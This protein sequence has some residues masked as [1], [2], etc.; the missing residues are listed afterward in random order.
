MTTGRRTTL[1]LALVAALF[2]VAAVPAAGASGSDRLYLLADDVGGLYWSTVARDPELGMTTISRTCGT[3]APALPESRDRCFGYVD[4]SGSR[5]Y[6]FDFHPA[7]L[8]DAKPAAS[9]EPLRFHFEADIASAMPATIHLATLEDHDLRVSEAAT[10]VAPGVWEGTLNDRAALSGQTN[11]LRVAVR[12]EAPRV[13]LRLGTG[14]SSWVDLPQPAV[15]RSVPEL[16]AAAPPVAGP[17]TY[18]GANRTVWFNDDDWSAWSFEGDLEQTRSFALDIP[19]EATVLLAWVET[20]STPVVYDVV[21]GRE[22]DPREQENAPTIR[23][24]RNSG[25]IA[26]GTN[27][28]VTGRGQDAAAALDVAAGPAV[29]EVGSQAYDPDGGGQELPYTVH[30][31]A[32]HGPRTLAGMR[33][34]FGMHGDVWTP[35]VGTCQYGLEPIP[36]TREVSTFRVDLDWDSAALPAPLWTLWFDLPIGEYVCGETGDTRRFTY[37]AEHRVRL[38]GPVPD[39]GSLHV[40]HND[41]VFEMEVQYTYEPG[42]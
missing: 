37:G 39:S 31:V 38:M 16:L 8:I 22:V 20:F 13:T 7:A 26:E 36:V 10:E 19:R 41:T 6:A 15:A 14:G 40:S 18:T 21:R 30:V 1:A 25:V 9:G 11:L 33:W 27:S 3:R 34:S 29:V 42:I 32:A 17:A 5:V 12:T 4:D 2:L 24:F 28:G 35:F 23:M